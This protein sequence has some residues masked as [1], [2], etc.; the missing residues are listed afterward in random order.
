MNI[1]FLI[2]A[3]LLSFL[4]LDLHPQEPE[5]PVEKKK[6]LAGNE[7]GAKRW[8]IVVGINEY[9]D[10]DISPLQKARNDAKLIAQILE[11]Q[12]QF[13]EVHLMTDDISPKSPLYPTRAHIEAK[14]DHVL[15]YST[16]VDTILFFFSGHGIS[17]S[18]GN[19]YLLSVD[20]SIEKSLITSIQVNDIMRKIKSRNVSK[21]ILFLDAC[22]DLSS[23]NAKGFAKEGFK[24]EKYASGDIPV[25]F[26]STSTG[27]YSYEDPKSNF[28]VFTKYLAH[29]MEGKADA[30][31]DGI[32][33]FSELE[34]FVRAGVVSWSDQNDK[35]QKPFVNYHRDKQGKIPI[36][37]SVDKV[38]SLVEE[39]NLPRSNSRLSAVIRSSLIPGWGQWYNGGNEKGL[40]YF[41]IFLILLGNSA[42]QYGPYAKAKSDYE[43]TL[44]LPATPGQGDTL[45]LNYF[46]FQPKYAAVNH[47]RNNFNL[48]IGL[49]GAFWAWNVLDLF[50]Y[51]G[52]NFF[53]AIN[54]RVAPATNPSVYANSPIEFDK[55]T[56]IQMTVRF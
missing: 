3:F 18:N 11:E 16:P 30:N 14:I 34:E 25:T 7:M 44:L 46:L 53:W 37:V 42:Y 40:S 27:Y 29:G 50:L 12:G 38:T 48:S 1:Y 19:G 28:G 20:T 8:A 39:N 43:S 47:A 36:T 6:S 51:K 52:N 10:K 32:V 24:S 56:D 55:K 13:E 9:T 23:S 17:D 4:A 45:A 31:Q 5:K 54:F 15:D 35:E 2:L 21:S 49:V 22:R 41:S 33:T 26:F